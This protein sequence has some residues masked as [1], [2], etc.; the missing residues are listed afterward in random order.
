M[1]STV[2]D[3]A[4]KW[5]GLHQ[6]LSASKVKFLGLKNDPSSPIYSVLHNA[7]STTQLSTQ[8]GK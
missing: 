7:D 6:Q 8:F 4:V 1:Q 3:L 2:R 5:E